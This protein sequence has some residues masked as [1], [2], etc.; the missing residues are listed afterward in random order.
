VVDDGEQVSEFGSAPMAAVARTAE[1]VAR[2]IRTSVEQVL[3]DTLS[4]RMGLVRALLTSSM[5]HS[6]AITTL[7]GGNDRMTAYS[8]VT[9][10]R[11]QLEALARG[12]FFS[13]MDK[14]T[15]EQVDYFLRNDELPEVPQGEGKKA[16]RPYLSELL[17][18]AREVLRA[19]LPPGLQGTVDSSFTYA[20]DVYNGFVHGGAKVTI[21][22]K[23]RNGRYDFLPDFKQVTLVAQ[24]SMAMAHF[25]EGILAATVFQYPDN[26]Q[27]MAERTPLLETYGQIVGIVK[28]DYG[29]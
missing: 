13:R 18:D 17:A 2:H 25:A 23:E 8:A 12:I 28:R 5:D 22:Y 24:H 15:D 4:P 16:R 27:A 14:S 11:P 10:F 3:V 19:F 21:A 7:L 26:L 20:L 29:L 6:V 1:P 9:L